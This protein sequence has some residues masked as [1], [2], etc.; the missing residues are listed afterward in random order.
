MIRRLERNGIVTRIGRG[1]YVETHRLQGLQPWEQFD[2]AAKAIAET[3]GRILG[4]Y[5]AAAAWKMWRYDQTPA[6]HETYRNGG[7]ARII[8]PP[9]IHQMHYVL[10]VT[11]IVSHGAIRWTSVDRTILDLARLHGFG[12]GFVAACSALRQGITTL[13]SLR[14]LDVTRMSGLAHWPMIVEHA[15]GTVQSALEAI[16]LAQAVFFGDFTLIPQPAVKGKNGRTYHPDF[17]VE[18]HPN[19][20]ELDGRGKYG[21]TGTEQEFHFGREKDRADNLPVQ[22]DRFSYS[23]VMR[24]HAYRSML[25]RLGLPPRAHLPPIHH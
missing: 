4:G 14:S 22:P 15:T 24:L 19:L 11:D 3:T 7:G 23:Q 2:L 20:I 12:A 17:G 10:P 21:G 8:G 1:A 16:F 18:G 13:D 5:S 6:Q 9:V 25:A